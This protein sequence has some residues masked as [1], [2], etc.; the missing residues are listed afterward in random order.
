LLHSDLIAAGWPDSHVVAVEF[1]NRFGGNVE[2]AA[3]IA[4]AARELIAATGSV[5]IDIVA[6]SMGGLA[7]R[8]FLNFGDGARHVRRVVFTGTPH[9]GTWAAY[10]AWGAGAADMRP[11]SH[12]LQQLRAAP[13]VPPGIDALCIHTPTET[14]VLP[15][16]SALLPG[17]RCERVWSLSHP[18]ML[19]SRR[20]FAAIRA[21]LRD[22]VI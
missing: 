16:S 8:Y 1:R 14:R 22:P 11:G 20:V 13:A 15:R 2:H 10:L 17:V 3:E 4:A 7:V 19:R 12:F 21:F 9:A 6:H 18:G 5:R